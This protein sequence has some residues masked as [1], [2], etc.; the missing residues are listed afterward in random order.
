MLVPAHMGVSW[1]VANRYCFVPFSKVSFSCP[2]AVWLYHPI[3]FVFSGLALV[4]VIWI[5][6]A[7]G[8]TPFEVISRRLD[9]KI[10]DVFF[11]RLRGG[12]E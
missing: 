7:Y 11:G 12:R 6:V 5:G 10:V 8:R 3:N 4:I 1:L 9:E 2:Y